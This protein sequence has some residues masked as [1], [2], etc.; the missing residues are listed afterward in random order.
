MRPL[1]AALA[2][3]LVGPPL[4][5]ACTVASAAV[6]P[7]SSGILGEPVD[8]TE[9]P[10]HIARAYMLD[11]LGA[12]LAEQAPA[13]HPVLIV[14][15]DDLFEQGLWGYTKYL[16][17]AELYVV[18]LDSRLPGPLM[19]NVLVHEWAHAIA[20]G[21]TE[22]SGHGPAW[23]VAYSQTYLVLQEWNATPYPPEI[24]AAIEEALGD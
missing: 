9:D 10:T 4:I 6:A 11:T 16:D 12:M 14:L 17:A 8:L 21:D 3:A 24:V 22:P 18:V 13:D 23:G 1:L 15:A 7:V 2:L 20:W 19:A 5:V